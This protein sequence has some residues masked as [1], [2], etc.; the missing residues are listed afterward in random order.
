MMT[1]TI[2][3]LGAL[4][5][6][7]AGCDSEVVGGGGGAGGGS[8]GSESIVAPSS[9]P[10][11]TGAGDTTTGN[12]TAGEGGG[13]QGTS[14]QGPVSSTSAGPGG[15][16]GGYALGAC[17]TNGGQASS[18]GGGAGEPGGTSCDVDYTCEG[19]AVFVT[20]TNDGN[21][22]SCDCSLDGAY[23]GS[24]VEQDQS[25]C[26]FPQN[27]CFDLLG[28]ETEPNPGPYGQCEESG[29]TATSSGSAGSSEFCGA[30]F[31]CTGGS[32]EIECEQ[33][34]DGGDA[35][36]ECLDS[37]GFL[38]GTCSQPSLDCGYETGCCYD[39]FN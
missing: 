12:P 5:V 23:V 17:E 19:G 4:A 28:G 1:R 34:S 7:V 36:C 10:A 2:L 33:P 21:G 20:C 30:Y 15:S 39:I 16:G 13:I 22:E 38:L 11:S 29:G 18:T 27:C 25:G 26:S 24:C 32:N 3:L 8:G 6:V 37:Q 14:G 31:D 9:T 35:R